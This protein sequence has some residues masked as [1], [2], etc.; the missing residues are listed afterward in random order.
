VLD[1]VLA[2]TGDRRTRTATDE[3]ALRKQVEVRRRALEQLID[4]ACPEHAADYGGRL[5]G[6]LL[7][8]G[9]EIDARSE[10]GLNRV[11]DLKPLRQLG[12]GPAAVA[13]LEYATI[14]QSRE[15]LLHE[16]RIA[17]RALDDDFAH[18]RRQP[19]AEQLVEQSPGVCG[20]QAL[21][22]EL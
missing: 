22:Q 8:A 9:Q 11:G 2:L 10:H 4:G 20:R 5:E 12:A 1:R 15:Q 13:A 14:D 6:C 16:E 18:G 21:E 3:V 17:L 19:D 7:R